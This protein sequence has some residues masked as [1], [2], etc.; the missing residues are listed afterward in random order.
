MAQTIVLF[1]TKGGTGKTTIVVNTAISLAKAGKKVL[2][3]DADLDVVGNAAW[4]LNVNPAKAMAD[5][6]YVLKKK[7]D[8]NPADIIT[9]ADEIDF[10][11]AVWPQQVPLLRIW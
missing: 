1:S 4:M 8:F 10:I 5:A 2:L 11:P 7:K 9:K 3:I 6:M